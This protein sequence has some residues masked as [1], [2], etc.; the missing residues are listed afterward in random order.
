MRALT[1]PPTQGSKY[2]IRRG[3]TIAGWVY[4]NT[5]F[6]VDGRWFLIYDNGVTETW[7]INQV[8]SGSSRAGVLWSTA[9][10]AKGDG[11][12]VDGYITGFGTIPSQRGQ[13]YVTAFVVD[14][15]A[16]GQEF[17]GMMAA[18]YLYFGHTV[19]LG[20]VVE[21]GPAGGPGALTRANL[22]SG[23]V[24]AGKVA[25]VVPI[26]AI[27]R[28]V[29]WNGVYTASATVGSRGYVA[30]IRDASGNI[31]LRT[32]TVTVIANQIGRLQLAP[33]LT[34]YQTVNPDP[35]PNAQAEGPLP[36]SALPAG[37]DIQV[38]DVSSIDG[39]DTTS[40]EAQVEEWVVPN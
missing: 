33:N 37:Y 1:A 7:P 16:T 13:A 8:A 26:G 35:T 40:A 2:R 17:T 19:A 5:A 30:R 22:S 4:S 23:T 25:A 38:L 6:T 34:S 15:I 14:T 24:G 12:V 28:W 36:A 9:Q 3:Q 20:Q 32:M 21:P 31:Y 18:G 27:W 29:A 11:W 39:L 10:V